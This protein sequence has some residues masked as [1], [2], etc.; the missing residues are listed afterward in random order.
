MNGNHGRKRS[1]RHRSST[2]KWISMIVLAGL[3][4]TGTFSIL[5]YR[6]YLDNLVEL[7]IAQRQTGPISLG[8]PDSS[9][10]NLN[11]GF[12]VALPKQDK[13][14]PVEGT[15]GWLATVY[16]PTPVRERGVRGADLGTFAIQTSAFR[17][18][19]A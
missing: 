4:S 6:A 8:N 14:A 2:Y 9:Q 13:P 12:T 10:A 16:R 17:F 7:R 19:V 3:V 11:D 18:A 15:R 1:S 5:L